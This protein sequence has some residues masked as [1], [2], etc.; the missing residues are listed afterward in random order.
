[1]HCNEM[2]M[3]SRKMNKEKKMPKGNGEKKGLT[4]KQKNLPPA[5]QKAIAAKKKK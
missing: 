1:M 4:A 2:E 3:K 5:L